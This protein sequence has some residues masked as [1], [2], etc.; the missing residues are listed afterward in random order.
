MEETIK[1][2]QDAGVQATPKHFIGY[3]QEI[4]RQP[5][6][7]EH[8]DSIT[9]VASESVSSNIDDRT[10]HELYMWPFAN[11]LRAGASTV[12]CSYN[13]INGSYACQNSKAINGLLKGELGFQGY[14]HSD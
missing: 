5:I 14:V 7:P 13:R 9:Q 12:M 4:H 11:A 3:E 6:Y 8:P 2:V 1:G 10:T